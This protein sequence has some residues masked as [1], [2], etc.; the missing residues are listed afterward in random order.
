MPP[1]QGLVSIEQ[2]DGRFAEQQAR[3]IAE[4]LPSGPGQS[5]LPSQVGCVPVRVPVDPAVV[6]Q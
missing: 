4:P 1:G 3:G 6:L 5:R 2:D